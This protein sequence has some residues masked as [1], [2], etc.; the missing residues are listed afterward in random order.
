MNGRLT[1]L[2]PAARA[3]LFAMHEAGQLHLK[4]DSEPFEGLE[5]VYDAIDRLLSS[6][7]IGKVVVKLGDA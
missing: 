7:S 6:R 3:R 4:F 1:E 2:W 5:T